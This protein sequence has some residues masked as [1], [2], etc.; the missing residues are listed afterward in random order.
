MNTKTDYEIAVDEFKEAD[1][2]YKEMEDKIISGEILHQVIP[3]DG[4]ATMNDVI[5]NYRM[6]MSQ[7][8]ELRDNRNT[9]LISA[10]AALRQAVQLGESQ[11][12]GPEAKATIIDY[13]GFSVSSVTRRKFDSQSLISLANEKGVLEEL[14]KLRGIDKEGKEIQLVEQSWKVDYEGIKQWLLEH[15]LENILMAS[16]DE[17][18]STPMVKGPKPVSFLGEPKDG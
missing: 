8:K 3:L 15:G 4:S 17:V 12:R 14:L 5:E 1:K 9:K 16:Y 13:S 6:A 10:K 7:L 18:E 11:W 2:V